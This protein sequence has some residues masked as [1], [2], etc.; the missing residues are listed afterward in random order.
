MWSEGQEFQGL[1]VYDAV[2]QQTK[3]I[4]QAK[5]INADSEQVTDLGFPRFRII[6][7]ETHSLIEIRLLLPM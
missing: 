4:R 2:S 5:F 6:A 3:L 1:L 7:E